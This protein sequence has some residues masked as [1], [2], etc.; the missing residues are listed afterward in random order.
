MYIDWDDCVLLMFM[1][2]MDSMCSTSICRWITSSYRVVFQENG[3]TVETNFITWKPFRLVLDPASHLQIILFYSKH[4]HDT[5][6]QF[7]FRCHV[8]KSLSFKTPNKNPYMQ[9]VSGG[10]NFL[11]TELCT[12]EDIL[13]KFYNPSFWWFSVAY[14]LSL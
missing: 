8:E 11:L 3:S 12:G 1:E 5:F 14:W 6:R 4:L 9:F 13:G 2:Y 7:I 10:V